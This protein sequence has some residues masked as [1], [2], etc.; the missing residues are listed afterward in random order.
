M[1][2]DGQHLSLPRVLQLMRARGYDVSTPTKPQHQ[3]KARQG[4]TAWVV[5]IRLPR[6]EFDIG[7]YTATR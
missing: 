4:L 6:A 2:D 1:S 7:F 3:P 5:H